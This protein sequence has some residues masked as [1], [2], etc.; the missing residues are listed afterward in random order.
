M[1]NILYV[2]YFINE[3][4]FFRLWYLFVIEINRYPGYTARTTTH[5]IKKKYFSNTL[6]Q[7]SLNLPSFQAVLQKSNR[8]KKEISST[9]SK[10]SK[11]VS[12]IVLDFLNNLPS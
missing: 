2:H 9:K 1:I 5:P 8:L 7:N 4:T 12:K 3:E 6:K 10:M 11:I